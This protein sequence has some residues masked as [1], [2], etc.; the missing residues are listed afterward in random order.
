MVTH[1]SLKFVVTPHH[2][3]K[4][5]AKENPNLWLNVYKLS[6]AHLSAAL[7]LS[8]F[9]IYFLLKPSPKQLTN[10]ISLNIKLIKQNNGFSFHDNGNRLQQAQFNIL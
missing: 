8:P 6:V 10:N 4:A 1:E 7:L 2:D 9:P 3:A 5:D